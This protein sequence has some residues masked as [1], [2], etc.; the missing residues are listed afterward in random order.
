[1]SATPLERLRARQA[2]LG[3]TAI[4]LA[5]A[6][7]KKVDDGFV[8]VLEGLKY[9]RA[10]APSPPATAAMKAEIDNMDLDALGNRVRKELALPSR[11]AAERKTGIGLHHAVDK[12]RTGLD[13]VD[14]VLLFGGIV[15]PG[16]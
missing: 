14:E 15:C 12:D 4:G 7:L 6:E 3:A 13:A 11:D 10:I 9:A 1:M 5:Q 2:A 16:R 8:S